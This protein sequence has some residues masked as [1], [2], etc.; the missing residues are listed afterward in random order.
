MR[1]RIDMTEVE[2][3]TKIRA[4]YLRALENEE[5]DLLPGPTF[6]KT[7]LR[8]YAEFLDLDPRLLVEEY[9]QRYERPSTQDLTPFGAGLGGQR[10]RRRQRPAAADRA[11]PRRARRRRRAARRALPA[12]RPGATTTRTTKPASATTATPTATATPTPAKKSATKKKKKAAPTRVTL[13]L[14]ATVAR[15]RVRRGRD[16]QG[17][18]QRRDARAGQGDQVVPLAALPREL[19]QRRRAHDASSGK[20]YQAAD[21]G[22]PIGYEI[23]PGKKPRAAEGIRADRSSA[24][25][26]RARG[27]RRHRHRGAVG[28]HRA[29]PTGR[30]CRSSCASTA[31]CS[32][33]RRRRRPARRPALGAGLPRGRGRRPDPHQRRPRADRR[34]PDRRR[35][36]GVGGGADAP[37]RGSGGAH[38]GRRD[39]PAGADA[40]GR[41]GDAGGRA[42]AGVRARGRRRARAGRH[43]AGPA[44]RRSGRWSRCCPGRRASCRRCGRTPS[45][46]SPLRELLAGAGAL[47]QRILRFFPLPEPQIAA[48]LRELDADALPL[49]ITTCLRRGEL[50]VAT[51]FAPP[52]AAAYADLEAALRERH[53]DVLFSDDGATI[54]E[55]VA[56]LLAGPHDRDRRVV[57]GRPDGGPADRPRGLLGLRAGRARRLLE[58]GQDRAGRRSGCADRGARRRVARGRHRA[59]GGRARAAGRRLRDRHHRHRRARAAAS[60]EKPVGTVCLRSS[61]AAD[62]EER[63]VRLPGGRADVRDRTTTVA[64]HMLRRCSLRAMTPAGCGSFVALRPARRRRVDALAPRVRR[65]LAGPRRLA[66]RVRA[67]VAARHARVPRLAPAGGRRR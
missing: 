30:G 25:R 34:R 10:R 49:E 46:T 29:T 20:R 5:W 39:A 1:R 66:R 12:R 62:S 37:R 19:R 56:R 7:F 24:P 4:K 52:D 63:T 14:T 57:H 23:R 50:E 42:Q 40:L 32:R 3:A 44:G 45:S 2:A 48:T 8:T 55:V 27:H 64:L 18:R 33:T 21:I 53:G 41:G 47:E 54:D 35:R 59:V 6:V 9:R 28:D 31:W 38:L 36:R 61:S 17:G 13:R 43:G 26:E 60:Q 51:V 65:P 15:L 16:R 22:A 58:R 11:V 67:A